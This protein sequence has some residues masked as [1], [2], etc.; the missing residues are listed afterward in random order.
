MLTVTNR[1]NVNT[2]SP[3]SRIR[4]DDTTKA[5]APGSGHCGSFCERKHAAELYSTF[6][7]KYIYNLIHNQTSIPAATVFYGI[8]K[9]LR[10]IISRA[11]FA[12][13][14][15]ET[16]TVDNL[17]SF[18]NITGPYFLES[19]HRDWCGN[20]PNWCKLPMIGKP[21]GDGGHCCFFLLLKAVK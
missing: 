2:R 9:E 5:K 20:S 11:C 7:S 15:E 8:D 1:H 4:H 17:P 16:T 10:N 12:V 19:L 18:R 21:G 6:G 14:E 3:N 13:L